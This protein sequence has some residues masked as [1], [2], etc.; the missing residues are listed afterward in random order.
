[1]KKASGIIE[2]RR[3]QW[4]ELPTRKLG[5]P[6][7]AG[8]GLMLRCFLSCFLCVLIGTLPV[9]AERTKKKQTEFGLGIETGFSLAQYHDTC[10][11]F[12]V[13]FIPGQYFE[14]LKQV[15]T[16][17]GARYQ[18]GPESFHNFPQELIINVEATAYRC[19]GMQDRPLPP[20]YGTSLLDDLAFQMNWR[21]GPSDKKSVKVVSTQIRHHQYGIR[22]DY[23]LEVC[24]EDIPLTDSLTIDVVAR[25]HINLAHID[26]DFK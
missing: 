4:W 16:T 14:G 11:V 19:S 18:K 15:Q 8:R 20:N 2:V 25:G 6:P 24:S 26:A 17:D 21:E 9:H 3:G 22:W 13:F 1:V 7:E 5:Q 10:V 12:R 23:F